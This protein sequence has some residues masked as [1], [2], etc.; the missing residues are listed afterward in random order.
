MVT[1]AGNKLDK[2]SIHYYSPQTLPFGYNDNDVYRA[3]VAAPVRIQNHLKATQDVIINNSNQD[4]K[5]AVTEYNSMYFHSL[6][7]RAR[8]MEAALQVAGQLHAFMSDPSLTDHNDYSCLAEFW[9]GSAIRLGQRGNF[10]TPS[11]HVLKL[12]S[13]KRGP[14]KVKSQVTCD[15][16][17][18]PAIGNVPALSN[19]PYIDAVA[20]RSMDGTRL[21]VSVINRNNT[22][23]YTVNFTLQGITGVQ[24]TANVYTVTANNYLDMNSWKNPNLI[25]LQSST[26][27]NA[28]TSFNY[29]LPKN[30]VTVFEFTVSGLTAISGPVLAGRVITSNGTPIEGATVTTDTGVQAITDKN[31]FYM[32][33]VPEGTYT[34]TATKSGYRNATKYNV[35]VYPV[36][37]T[38]SSPI[39]MTP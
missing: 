33:Q 10:V 39:K 2:L 4:I 12:Y 17:N 34:L 19:V 30:S 31:G 16:F 11:F 15:T 27:S 26:I 35:Y 20:T 37:G 29:T 21:Y 18:S 23:G 5:I 24:P 8:S 14:I 28:S 1:T 7:R 36:T 3:S 32:M 22:S 6:D 25:P 9:D 13:N 38:T